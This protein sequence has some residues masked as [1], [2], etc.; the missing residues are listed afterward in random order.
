M[1]D[2]IDPRF[3]AQLDA[4]RLSSRREPRRHARQRAHDAMLEALVLRSPRPRRYLFLFRPRFGHAGLLA[5]AATI[6]AAAGVAFAGWNAPPGSALFVV[7]EARQGIMLKLPGSN[8]AALHLQFAELSLADARVSAD[9]HQSLADARAELAAAFGELATD[10]TSPLWSRYRIDEAVLVTEERSIGDEGTSRPT[11]PAAPGPNGDDTPSGTRAPGS[12]GDD[13]P[14][15]G[16]TGRTSPSPSSGG[17]GDGGGG[18]DGSPSP[19][20]TPPPDH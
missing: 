13:S 7:R 14:S 2:G 19:G 18:D 17:G 10:Q 15:A 9:P 11:N 5:A 4:W 16:P 8:G 1:S 3:S 6:L 12:G 20:A